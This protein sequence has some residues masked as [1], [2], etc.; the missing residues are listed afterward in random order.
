MPVAVSLRNVVIRY[1]YELDGWC[2]ILPEATLDSA[3]LAPGHTCRVN[4]P[5]TIP[6]GTGAETR[7]SVRLVQ[8][9][10][11]DIYDTQYETLIRYPDGGPATVISVTQSAPYASPDARTMAQ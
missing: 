8:A 2:H 3:A 11:K 4:P 9:E 7:I 1:G 5:G 10:Y 6:N